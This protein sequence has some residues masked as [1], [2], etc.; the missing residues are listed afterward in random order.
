MNKLKPYEEPETIQ[1]YALQILVCHILEVEIRPKRTHSKNSTTKSPIT[2]F[3]Q[4]SE[5]TISHT[6]STHYQDSEILEAEDLEI[7]QIMREGYYVQPS[8]L[9][10]Q[11]PHYMYPSRVKPLKIDNT[12]AIF[13]EEHALKPPKQGFE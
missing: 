9:C 3:S 7:H 4:P 1:A 8:I 5:E 10:G 12:C 11:N 6:E 13:Q 2:I